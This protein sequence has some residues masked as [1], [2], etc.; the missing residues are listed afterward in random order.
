MTLPTAAAALPTAL[1]V[2]LAAAP[3]GPAAVRPGAETLA[4]LDDPVELQ[5]FTRFATGPDGVRIAD[6]ALRL[7][8]MHCAACAGLIEQAVAAVAGVRA[9]SVSAAGERARVHWDPALTTVAAV[10]AAIQAAGYGATPDAAL[11]SREL[12]RQESRR[13]VWRLFVAAFCAMQVMMLATPSYVAHG[14]ELAPDLRQLL[15]WGSWLL[16]LP[17]LAFAA[18]PFFSGA[19][20][21]LRQRRIGMDVPVALGIAVT[22]VASSGATFAPAG[23]F[24]REVY[25]DSLTMFVAFLLAGRWLETRARHRVAQVLEAALD[26][27]PATA[28]RLDD[29]DQ[30]QSVSVQRLQPGD[31]VRVPVGQAFPADGVLLAGATRADESLLTGESAAVA[32]ACGAALVGGSINL[33]APVVMQLQRVGADTRLQA[34]VALMRDAMSQ[35]PALARAA[36][37]WAAPFL[38]LVLLLAAGAGAVWSVVDPSRAVWVVVSVLIV[39]CP[40]ALSLAAPSAMLAAASAL[41]RRGVLLQRLDALEVLTRVQRVYLDKTGTVTDDQLQCQGL[42]RQA[43]PA[44][45]APALAGWSDNALQQRA[46]SLANWSGHPLSRALVAAVPAAGGVVWR[47]VSE[48]AGQGLLA[49]DEAGRQWRLGA[50]DFVAPGVQDDALAGP[51]VWL[52]CDG[53]ALASFAFEEALRPDAISTVAALRAQGLQVMLLSGDRPERARRM[54]QRLAVDGV[55]GGATPE[56]KL[57]E[58]AAAQAGGLTVLMVGDGV[59]DAPVLARADVSLAMGQGALVARAQADATLVSGRLADLLTARQVAQRTMRVVRQNIGWAVAYNLACIP[60]ALGG[61][62]PPWAAG[63]GMASSSLLVIGNAVR[64]AR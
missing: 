61:W 9:V 46:A 55:I 14:D 1:S 34:I 20:R 4:V 37:R 2:A 15:N 58:V 21:S 26:G 27:L 41:A 47:D 12:R 29:H 28:L 5:R 6:S 25:F 30:V 50:A 35:R 40:C 45:S 59:N 18:G 39:T 23:L 33:G 48:R 24:G 44:G 51:Q 8:G 32:K 22:F 54:G 64:L 57:A 3:A 56:R 36:D 62:L 10:V 53:V 17:V 31:R 38:W 42:R 13:A 60:L 63:L 11:A 49:H 52:G 43:L 19:W 16:T 7:S